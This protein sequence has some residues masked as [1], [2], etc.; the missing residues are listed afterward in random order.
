MEEFTYLPWRTKRLQRRPNH[1]NGENPDPGPSLPVYTQDT[2]PIDLVKTMVAH[3]SWG[4]KDTYHL[5]YYVP[6]I[7]DV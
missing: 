3:V 7:K 1:P 2:V 5:W 6:C 4:P